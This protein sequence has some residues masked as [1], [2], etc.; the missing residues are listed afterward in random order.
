MKQKKKAE[1]DNPGKLLMRILGYVGKTY[2]V[3]LILVVIG[4]FVSVLANVQGTMFMKTMIDDYIVPLLQADVPDFRP[5]AMAILRVACLYAI[6]VACA[7][8][9]NKIMI[10][11]TQG[12]LKNLRDD[13]FEKM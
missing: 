12:T 11:V 9:Y 2:K 4:I 3:H 1:V 5:F 13:M 8:A 7:Y 6:G 10:Y